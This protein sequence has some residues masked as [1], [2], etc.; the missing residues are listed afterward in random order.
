[1][2]CF[3]FPIGEAQEVWNQFRELTADYATAF[4]IVTEPKRRTER[5]VES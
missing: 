1:M 4:T 2:Y 5:V 3:D